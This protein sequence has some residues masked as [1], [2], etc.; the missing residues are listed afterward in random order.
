[1]QELRSERVGL[2]LYFLREKLLS[3]IAMGM[4]K[5]YVERKRL[6]IGQFFQKNRF[7]LL[8]NTA[9][10]LMDLYLSKKS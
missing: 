4:S 7:L 9:D 3:N 8:Y 10:K 2:K 5:S 1:M 6:N